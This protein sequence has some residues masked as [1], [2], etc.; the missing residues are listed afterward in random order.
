[1]VNE[2]IIVLIL[3][4]GFGCIQTS[5]FISKWMMKKDIR[6]MGSGNAGASNV[7]VTMGFHFGIL[8]GIVDIMKAYCSVI[9]IAHLFPKS[10]QLAELEV[11]A[12]SAA[13]MGHIFPFFMNFKGGKGIACYIGL[14]LGL[15]FYMGLNIILFLLISTVVTDFVSVGSILIYLIL[16]LF[17]L[18]NIDY[19]LIS[20]LIFVV[21][22][23][24][25]IFKHW[26]NV[27][28]LIACEEI[29]LRSTM[30]KE[31]VAE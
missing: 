3:G 31:H 29:G 28:R 20:F 26:I 18:V 27:K 13:I 2:W 10:T 5:Y 11:L 1:M 25:G 19:S 6:E 21:V 12:G 14:L 9:S 15:D 17:I 4:Y 7:T 8:T 16:P 23:A 30:R 24:V 22:G